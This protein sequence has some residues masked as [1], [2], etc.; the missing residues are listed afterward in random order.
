MV[1]NNSPRWLETVG[2]YFPRLRL[3]KYGSPRSPV[4]SGS[5]FAQFPSWA[6]NICILRGKKGIFFLKDDLNKTNQWEYYYY[7]IVCVCLC[8][9]LNSKIISFNTFI[10]YFI[11]AWMMRYMLTIINRVRNGNVHA[12]AIVSRWKCR[13]AISMNA[14]AILVTWISNHRF[15]YRNIEKRKNYNTG[16]FLVFFGKFCIFLRKKKYFSIKN[17]LGRAVK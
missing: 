12:V 14:N 6:V 5:Y 11:K 16:F 8:F 13:L 1:Q 3:G 9:I 2:L 15:C 17:S 10:M 7:Y 4:T